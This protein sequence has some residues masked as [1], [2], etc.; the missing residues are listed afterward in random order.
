MLKRLKTHHL[1][2]RVSFLS[3]ST[4]HYTLWKNPQKRQ[5]GGEAQAIGSGD[6]RRRQIAFLIRSFINPRTRI[7]G[8]ICNITTSSRF[9]LTLSRVITHLSQ[10]SNKREKGWRGKESA[11]SRFPAWTGTLLI[12]WFSLYAQSFL[13]NSISCNGPQVQIILKKQ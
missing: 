4:N 10:C 2:Q 3:P 6:N 9:Y 13:F 5:R 1:L 11:K 7:E 8:I 12:I